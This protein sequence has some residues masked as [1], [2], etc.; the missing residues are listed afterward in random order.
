MF[1]LWNFCVSVWNS[2]PTLETHF[3]CSVCQESVSIFSYSTLF[4]LT[5]HS[6]SFTVRM[7]L[8]C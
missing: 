5:Y 2:R 7:F 3:T 1:F 8:L 4:P 6:D